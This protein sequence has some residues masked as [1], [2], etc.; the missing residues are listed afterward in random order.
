MTFEVEFTEEFGEWWDTLSEEQQEAVYNRVRKL[1]REGPHLGRPDADR[2]EHSRYPNMKELRGPGNIR[3]L[4]IFDP[5][6]VAILLLG[7]DK[8]GQWK[9]W[10]RKA[11]PR[12]E[13]IYEQY[14]AELKEEGLI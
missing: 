10:Y 2:L 6:G 9:R 8:T 3:T 14:L 7:G 11:I 12:A 1:Q 4:F 13:A 5:R